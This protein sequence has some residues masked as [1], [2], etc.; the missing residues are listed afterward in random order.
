[1]KK[2]ALLTLVFT[3]LLAFNTIGQ[4]SW[5]LDKAHGK[6]GFTITHLMISEV[7]GWFKNFDA[8]I[9]GNN[10][11]YSDASV[12]M[13][14]QIISINTDNDKRDEHLKSADFFDATKYPTLTFKSK[15]FKKVGD[16]KYKVTGNLTIHG[17]TKSIELDATARTGVNPMSKKTVTGFKITGTLKRSDFALGNTF[18]AAILSDEVALIANA[19]FNKD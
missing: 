12:E 11:D 16:N 1:M 9:T 8:K 4:T 17:V 14:A 3:S 15:S 13:T 2:S 10:D 5:S 19:E 18:P 6:V 7:E